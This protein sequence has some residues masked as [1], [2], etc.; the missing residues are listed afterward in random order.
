MYFT[1]I[2]KGQDGLW[3]AKFGDTDRQLVLEEQQDYRGVDWK[4]I[5]TRS[6][7]QVHNE[8]AAL[9]FKE[10]H[11]PRSKAF[12]NKLLDQPPGVKVIK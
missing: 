11:N 12:H 5:K 9:N 3:S 10:L 2:T 4:I 8:I 7:R 1:L 6:Q